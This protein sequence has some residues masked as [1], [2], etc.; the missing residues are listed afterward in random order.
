M[1]LNGLLFDKDGTLVDFEKTWRP[2][3][4]ACALLAAS[5]DPALAARLLQA[6]GQDASGRIEPTSVLACGTLEEVWDRWVP[7]V[8]VDRDAL[9]R[10][11][12][13]H[14]VPHPLTDVPALFRR[15]SAFRLGIATM[16][17]TRQAD[18][19]VEL[20]GLDV[21]FCTG[22]DGGHGLKPG[23]GMVHGFCAAT[24]LAP[25]QVA[26]VGDTLHDLHMASAAG[27]TA[28]AVTTGASPRNL[29]EPHADHVITSLDELPALL[30][31]LG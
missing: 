5:G 13:D 2:C 14:L 8:D 6:A 19:L 11:A 22:F 12:D 10:C 18:R 29:L 30:D 7:Q 27:A 25:S 9:N 3:Y 21:D 4:D 26:V 20:W 1:T 28:I 15:L 23:P 16:D 17:S 24:G 31:S